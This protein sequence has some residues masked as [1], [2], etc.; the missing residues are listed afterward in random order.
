MSDT[1]NYVCVLQYK[2]IIFFL[3][4]FFPTVQA[5]NMTNNDHVNHDNSL[6]E[7]QEGKIYA[8][9]AFFLSITAILAVFYHWSK[10][11]ERK[12]ALKSFEE[13]LENERKK[14]DIL[15][16]HGLENITAKKHSFRGLYNNSTPAP[17]S[18]TNI[19]MKQKLEF[20]FTENPKSRL[21]TVKKVVKYF[22]SIDTT[23]TVE[24]I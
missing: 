2:T 8:S 13:I 4:S 9:L 14:K 17:S 20:M 18:L 23:E 5:N 3:L 1:K 15:A 6:T 19:E 10:H 24:P 16:K 12:E 21:S 11:L 22:G 7:E